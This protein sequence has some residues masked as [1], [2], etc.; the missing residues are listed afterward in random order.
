M[1]GGEGPIDAL[2]GQSLLHLLV[3]LDVYVIIVCNKIVGA[4]TLKDND[5]ND[6]KEEAH[7]GNLPRLIRSGNRGNGLLGWLFWQ[8]L[9][10]EFALF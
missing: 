4:H 3:I 8:A 6:S 7:G 1:K 2:R 5:G 9:G 10:T